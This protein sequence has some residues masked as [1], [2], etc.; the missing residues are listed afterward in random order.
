M[1]YKREKDNSYCG[2]WFALAILIINLSAG[3]WSV[4]YLL[5]TLVEKTIPLAGAILIGAI[6]GELSIPTAVVVWLLK[7]FNIF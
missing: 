1:Q 2:C 3:A 5:L 7:A 6:V 4:N